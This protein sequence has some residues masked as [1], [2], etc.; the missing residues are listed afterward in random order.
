MEDPSDP[1]TDPW[2][3]GFADTIR[4]PKARGHWG[5]SWK[6]RQVLGAGMRSGFFSQ[7][8]EEDSHRSN[9]RGVRTLALQP[10]S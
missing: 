10:A 7:A 1:Q 6:G 4:E 9:T 8:K 3:A 5:G 2:E